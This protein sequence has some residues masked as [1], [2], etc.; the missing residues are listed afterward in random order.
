MSGFAYD[1]ATG[2]L[3]KEVIEP[4]AGDVAGCVSA[5]AGTGITLIT[6]H[7]HDKYGNR[8]KATVS[9]PG[10]AARATATAWGERAA[11]GTVTANGRFAVAATNALGPRREALARPGLWRRDPAARPQ[12]SGDRLEI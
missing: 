4:G 10:I 3:T 8:N 9:G 5:A 1:A 6:A 2:L 12:R 11:D 7:G